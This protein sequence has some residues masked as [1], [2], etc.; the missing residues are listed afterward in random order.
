ML[1]FDGIHTHNS[2]LAKPVKA[3]TVGFTRVNGSFQLSAPLD[4]SGADVQAVKLPAQG[5]ETPAGTAAVVTG[6]GATS[7]S[8]F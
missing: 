2:E 4:L 7:V 5:Q 3:F 6:W 8:S 1:Y